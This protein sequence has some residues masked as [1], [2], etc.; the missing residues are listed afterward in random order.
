MK[1]HDAEVSLI[2]V[3]ALAGGTSLLTRITI[4]MMKMHVPRPRN[5]S[6]RL[7]VL[8]TSLRLILPVSIEILNRS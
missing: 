7:I 1:H 5:T 4:S 8:L 6:R 2:M 3:R